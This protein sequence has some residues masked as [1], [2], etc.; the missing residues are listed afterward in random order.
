MP[1]DFVLKLEWRR[2]SDDDNSG[3]FLRF[4]RPDS[5]GYDNTAFVAVD[6]GFEVQIDQLARDD[7]APT[8]KTAAIYGLAAPDDP[9]NLPVSAP[10]EWNAYEIRVQGQDYDVLLNGTHVTHFTNLDAA[11]GLPSTL[12]VPSFIGLQAHTGRVGF[13]RVQLKAL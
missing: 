5:K 13:R 6:F 11:R 2:W 10:G 7:G 1:A 9:A 12:A 3:V 8:H 4:P